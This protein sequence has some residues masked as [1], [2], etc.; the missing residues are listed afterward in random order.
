MKSPDENRSNIRSISSR[1]RLNN[2]KN[3]LAISRAGSAT[4]EHWAEGDFAKGDMAMQGAGTALR[5]CHVD[6]AGGVVRRV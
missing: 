1:F 5:D 6:C 2:S 3:F 4:L